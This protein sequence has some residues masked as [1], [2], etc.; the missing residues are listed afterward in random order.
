MGVDYALVLNSL[1]QAQI[2]TL[3][4]MTND[5]LPSSAKCFLTN[6]IDTSG[7]PIDVDSYIYTGPPLLRMRPFETTIGDK[8]LP[9]SVF[10]RKP[11]WSAD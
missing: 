6:E 10:D 3:R 9:N 4:R 2:D 1:D 5:S 8:R 11:E 7:G